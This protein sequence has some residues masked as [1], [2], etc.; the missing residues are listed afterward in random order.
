[1]AKTQSTKHGH[2][3][4]IEQNPINE[5][6]DRLNQASN[7]LRGFMILLS[8]YDNSSVLKAEQIFSL[9]DPIVREVDAALDEL[10]SVAE[11]VQ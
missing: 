7:A 5:A 6:T 1:M 2:L 10:R 9:L 11:W 8:G 4:V 3:R